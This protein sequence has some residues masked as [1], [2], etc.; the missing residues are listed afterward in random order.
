MFRKDD[1]KEPL[2]E[3][4]LNIIKEMK[5]PG[6]SEKHPV[7]IAAPQNDDL[8]DANLIKNILLEKGMR[9]FSEEDLGNYVEFQF[10]ACQERLNQ[11]ESIFEKTN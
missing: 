8:T 11:N 5:V 10:G 9:A 3:S 2:I 4:F 1:K 7:Y 6:N